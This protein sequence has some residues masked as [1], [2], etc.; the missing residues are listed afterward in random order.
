MSRAFV[1]R[2]RDWDEAGLNLTISGEL[3]ASIHLAIPRLA[4]ALAEIASRPLTPRFV[5]AAL[6]ITTRERLRWTEDGRLPGSGAVPTHRA[7]H[8]VA[9]PTYAVSMVEGL[10]ARPEV[11]AAWRDQDALDRRAG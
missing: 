7:A 6:N 8:V 1:G 10:L 9:V 11:I 5:V 2:A 3:G 4:E